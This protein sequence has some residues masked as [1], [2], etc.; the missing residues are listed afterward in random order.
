[1]AGWW[2]GASVPLVSTWVYPQGRLSILAIWWLASPRR[3]DA[4]SSDGF[5]D[6]ASKVTHHRAHRVLLVTL[7]SSIPCGK[8]LQKGMVAEAKDYWGPSWRL[9]TSQHYLLYINDLI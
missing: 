4:R 2:A 3:S 1:M 9:A 8:E 5:Y 7:A 6:L